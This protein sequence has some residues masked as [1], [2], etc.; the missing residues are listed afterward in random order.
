MTTR[1][2]VFGGTELTASD[3]AVASGLADGMKQEIGAAVCEERLAAC[4]QE[5]ISAAHQRIQEMFYE[6]VDIVK[7]S[8]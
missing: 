4:D 3:V 6:L 1:S 8:Q 5:V 2:I 7:V